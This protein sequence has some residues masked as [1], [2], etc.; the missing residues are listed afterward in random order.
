MVTLTL[1]AGAVLDERARRELNAQLAEPVVI[2]AGRLRMKTRTLLPGVALE[3][4]ITLRYEL[5]GELSG[6][7]IDAWSPDRPDRRTIVPPRT[8]RVEVSR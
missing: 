1:P 3:L 8:L 6:F 5:G 7:G 2:E 4:P